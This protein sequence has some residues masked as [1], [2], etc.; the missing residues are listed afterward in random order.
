M[1][2]VTLTP[3]ETNR[4]SRHLILPEIGLAG[5]QKLKEAKVLVIGAGGLG[6]PVLQ[7]LTAAGVGTI[8]IVDFDR[9]EESNLQRQILFSVP[10]VGRLKAEVAQEKLK[11]Q[12]PYVH[13][14]SYPVHLQP[15]NALELL[16]GYDL[17]IDGSDNFA[18]R[19]LVNDACVILKKPLVFGS[20]FKFEGQ[21]SVF[22]Y[23]GGPTYRCLYP[24]ASELAS[25]SEVGVLGVLPGLVGCLLANEAIKVITGLGEIA[26]GKLLV[27]NALTLQF[28][29]YSFGVN[30]MNLSITELPM[31]ASLCEEPITDISFP[32]LLHKL[33]SGERFTLLDVRETDE[34][35]REHM[36]G[37]LYPLS[38]LEQT[39]PAIPTNRPVV[40]HCQSGMRSK[41]ACRLLQAKGFTNLYNL[42][43]GI[44]RLTPE[45]RTQL[46]SH[47]T[48]PVA[49]Q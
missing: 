10:D 22:N 6:C 42:A 35:L 13:L 44:N 19:Y 38:A 3:E 27:L 45:E 46:A 37:K 21:I 12:N 17:V 8:G 40:V 41:K 4:Y 28:N 20:I 31:E 39:W 1:P 30:P 14:I 9:V 23:Q 33:Q 36:G 25:C 48:S 29:T 32:D 11:T 16:A 15:Q 5:Q 7:Y 47:F 34:Y 18:T 26:A 49:P 43:G 24:E 2:S